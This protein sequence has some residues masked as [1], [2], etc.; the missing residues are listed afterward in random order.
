MNY[1]FPMLVLLLWGALA[2]Y[3]FIKSPTEY[4]VRWVMIPA[5]LVAAVAFGFFVWMAFGYAVQMQLPD[6]FDFLGYHT[7]IEGNKK[8][9]I[10][11]WIEAERTRLYV[12]P[13]SK[14]AEEK[15]KKAAAEKR[16]GNTVRMKR[17]GQDHGK[18]NG[19]KDGTDGTQG[20]GRNGEDYPYDSNVLLPKDVNPKTDGDRKPDPPENSIL[21]RSWV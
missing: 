4:L 19:L 3:V 9:A 13:Y 5:S 7:V 12:I 20:K 10:E 1:L 6:E 8:T 15:L 16:A 2:S 21:D 18:N 17:K 11:I 14:D